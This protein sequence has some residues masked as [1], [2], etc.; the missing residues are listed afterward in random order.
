MKR[1]LYILALLMLPAVALSQETASTPQRPVFT[2]VEFEGG[3]GRLVDTY[4]SPYSYSGWNIALNIEL[5]Q[6]LKLDDYNW[7]WQQ[8]IGLNYGSTRLSISGA[9]LTIMGGANYSFAMMHRSNTPIEGLQLYYG[10]NFSLLGEGLYNYH[11]GNN[12]ATVK[13]DISLGL[14]AMAV[15]NF[16]IGKLPFTT[17][18]QLQL[19]VIGVFAQPEYGESYYEVWLGNYHNFLHCGTWANRFDIDNRITLDMHFGSWALRMGYHNRINT[20]YEN[21]NRYQLVMHNFTVGFAGDL[22]SIDNKK[23]NRPIVRALY[24]IAQ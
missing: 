24:N 5:M 8:L 10:G 12:P 20:T 2:A 18:Y 1:L 14:T 21:N 9:G 17:R 13:A 3:G 4:L 6:A 15:Y 23:S 19:P 22:L 7:V 16:S 11:G